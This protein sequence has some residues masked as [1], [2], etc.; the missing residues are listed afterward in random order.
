MANKQRKNNTICSSPI[1]LL[2][3][4]VIIIN[5]YPPLRTHRYLQYFCHLFEEVVQAVV[6]LRVIRGIL[7]DK[8]I[9]VAGASL[10]LSSLNMGENCQFT[11]KLWGE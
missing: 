3:K 5:L 9:F 1:P 2:V 11:E 8:S 6:Q 10:S 4:E 7:V